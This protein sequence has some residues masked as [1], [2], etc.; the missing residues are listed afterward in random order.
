MHNYT[1]EMELKILNIIYNSKYVTFKTRMFKLPSVISSGISGSIS[2]F[3]KI[4]KKPLRDQKIRSYLKELRDEGILK[5]DCIK[6][7]N[8][9]DTSFYLV[10]GEKLN[11]KILNNKHWL[12]IQKLIDNNIAIR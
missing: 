11:E 4:I 10:D 8:G 2:D 12:D 1:P 6:N 5:F 3:I 7:I 9:A